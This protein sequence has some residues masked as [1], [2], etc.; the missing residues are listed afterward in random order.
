MTKDSL[1]K[2]GR[3]KMAMKN[4]AGQA[5]RGESFFKRPA[6][7]RQFHNKIDSGSSILI[8]APR[9]V[10]KTSLMLH[11][12][13]NPIPQCHF[14]Y[15]I[16]ESVN[17]ENE[18]FKRFLDEIFETE[19]LSSLQKTSKK[20]SLALKDRMARIN[21]IGKT[22][23][24]DKESRLDFREEFIDIIKSID[25]GEQK[26]I[27]MIDEFSQT[28]E[29]IIADEGERSAVHFLQ[30]NRELRQDPVLNQKLQFVY[31]GSIG[32][33]NIVNRLDAINLV[34][35]L[36][37]MKVPPLSTKESHLLMQELT[38]AWPTT[39]SKACRDYIL[40]KIQWYIPFYIQLAV[41]E[42]SNLLIRSEEETGTVK[43][44]VTKK[45]IDNAFTLMLERRNA[46]EHWQTRLRKAFKKEEY[47]FAAQVLDSISHNESIDSGE[48]FNMALKIDVTGPYKD[49]VNSLVHDGYINNNDEPSLYRFNSPLLRI[50]WRKNA[51][52]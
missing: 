29:N 32:L 19:F 42:I 16:T 49:I 5:V 7:V 9:R 41:M 45:M 15:L 28:V 25:L 22:V 37:S 34:N 24:F 31:S 30:V 3:S 48:I 26:L 13:D 36:D 44:R 18:Y 39:L 12:H 20:T 35:D 10:G 52:H 14:I 8:A 38:A 51:A 23:K 46:F 40:D 4:I 50:W 47:Q 17:N 21:E 11:I 6:L 2:G 33:E 43:K 1:S 27:M